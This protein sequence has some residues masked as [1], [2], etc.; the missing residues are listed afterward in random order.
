MQYPYAVSCAEPKNPNA[1][2]VQ[3]SL[4]FSEPS[5]MKASVEPLRLNPPEL[6]V[7]PPGQ[8]PVFTVAR[9]PAG[10]LV[11]FLTSLSSLPPRLQ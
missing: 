2:C 1:D 6:S 8:P 5:P 3:E 10:T 4:A 7:F 11:D 9:P